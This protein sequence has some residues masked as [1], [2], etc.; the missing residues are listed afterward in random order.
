VPILIVRAGRDA[1]PGLDASMQRF[2]AAAPARG[3][4]IELVDHA[5]APHAFDLVDESPAT[6]AAIDRVLAFLREQL[7]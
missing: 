4:E 1:M 5:D 6:H 7:G 3:V 2:L